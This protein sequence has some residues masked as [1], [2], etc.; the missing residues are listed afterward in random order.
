MT[1]TILTRHDADEEK[2]RSATGRI[3]T[4]PQFGNCLAVAR[5]PIMLM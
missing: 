4:P 3:Y 2:K 5:A 1:N